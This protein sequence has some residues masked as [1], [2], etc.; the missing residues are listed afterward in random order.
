MKFLFNLM[1]FALMFNVI[2]ADDNVVWSGKV[3]SNGHP[4]SSIKLDLG[5][6]Y[7]I[8]ANG[9]INLGKWWQQKH[10]LANDAC[11]EFSDL[12]EPPVRT[13]FSALKNSLNVSVC[14]GTYHEDH[15]Y[16]SEPFTAVNSG[17]HFWIYDTNYDD[18]NG[19]MDVQLIKVEDAKK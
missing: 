13:K 8:I 11:Y 15:R 17:I 9:E 7:K 12:T 5:A 6:T 10:P 4:T 19:E 18:N 2:N 16:Q 1:I 14:D 3:N